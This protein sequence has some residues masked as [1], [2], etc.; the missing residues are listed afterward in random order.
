MR[1]SEQLAELRTPLESM[2]ARTNVALQEL[3]SAQHRLQQIESQL[4]TLLT[5][6]QSPSTPSDVRPA[7]SLIARILDEASPS[8]NGG[9]ARKGK[10]H[11]RLTPPGDASL[12][13]QWDELEM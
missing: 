8:V 10:L 9:Y 1:H 5:Y 4:V 11:A 13:R 6:T 2:Q 7:S 12:T 3:H